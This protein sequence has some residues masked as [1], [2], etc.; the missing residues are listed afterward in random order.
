MLFNPSTIKF[1]YFNINCMNDA[2]LLISFT[3]DCTKDPFFWKIHEMTQKID[4]SFFFFDLRLLFNFTF[5]LMYLKLIKLKITFLLIF[6]F[7]FSR[8]T[9]RSSS[10]FCK[11]RLSSMAR[12]TRTSLM[13]TQGSS[14]LHQVRTE[15]RNYCTTWAML[16]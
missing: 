6:T 5:S 2:L 11:M 13:K 15:L 12:W 9:S 4:L 16:W 7:S 14:I 3:D 8:Q 1:T 10:M